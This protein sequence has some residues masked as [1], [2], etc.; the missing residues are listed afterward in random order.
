MLLTKEEFFKHRIEKVKEISSLFGIMSRYGH[1][2]RYEDRSAQLHCCFLDYHSSGRDTKPSARYYPK[3]ERGDFETY[4]CW[5]CTPK[6][7]DVIGFVQRT[8]DISF[9]QAIHKLEQFYS[10]QYEDIDL[11]KDFDPT[12]THTS[13]IDPKILFRYNEKLL[14]DNRMFFK[15]ESFKRVCYVLD[16]IYASYDENNPTITVKRLTEWSKKVQVMLQKG[17]E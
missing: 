6:P 3:G 13:K 17:P 8:E 16:K 9:G 15:L 1:A 11:E 7:L 10:I 14:K 5:V 2:P 4:Y 12:L